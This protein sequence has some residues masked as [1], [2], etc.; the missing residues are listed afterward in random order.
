[1][2]T[3]IY[4]GKSDIGSGPD[5]R[6][7]LSAIIAFDGDLDKLECIELGGGQGP[8]EVQ[9]KHIAPIV[10]TALLSYGTREYSVV[11]DAAIVQAIIGPNAR[12][13]SR[14]VSDSFK[15]SVDLKTGSIC[16]PVYE[17]PDRRYA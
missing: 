13:V 10:A 2:N 14:E 12:P 7:V 16:A 6:T 3:Q 17:V 1:M 8:L 11:E 9:V 4:L 15:K 5:S